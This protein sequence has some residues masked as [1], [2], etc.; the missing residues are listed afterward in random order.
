MQVTVRRAG[1]GGMLWLSAAACM[2]QVF[3]IAFS[4]VIKCMFVVLNLETM[5]NAP[6]A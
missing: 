6:V 2:K 1:K 5:I 4:T 3:I